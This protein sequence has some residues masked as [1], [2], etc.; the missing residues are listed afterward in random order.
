[1]LKFIARKINVLKSRELTTV[2]TM[3]GDITPG[4]SMEMPISRM[5]D[6]WIML[7]DT[8]END[9]RSTSLLITKSRG[10][11]HSNLAHRLTLSNDGVRV[12]SADQGS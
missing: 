4:N 2:I 12:A 1:V 9:A 10:I 11:H 5:V 8:E 6:T 7:R 3:F